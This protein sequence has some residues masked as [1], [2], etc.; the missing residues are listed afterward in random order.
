MGPGRPPASGQQL[1][2][3]FCMNAS[4]SKGREEKA[5]LPARSNATLRLSGDS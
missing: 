3:L 2:S 4:D 5:S 1:V